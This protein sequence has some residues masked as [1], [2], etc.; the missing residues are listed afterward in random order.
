MTRYTQI[1]TFVNVNVLLHL[2]RPGCIFTRVHVYSGMYSRSHAHFYT[3]VKIYIYVKFTYVCKSAHVNCSYICWHTYYMY[4]QG[5][6]RL[7]S[8]GHKLLFFSADDVL[9]HI[10]DSTA[11]HGSCFVDV[12]APL[13]EQ[14]GT[15]CCFKLLLS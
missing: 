6:T 5:N 1:F 11:E 12:S 13:Q 10:Q 7:R 2:F 3:P 14:V 15:E 4:W 9:G 8:P